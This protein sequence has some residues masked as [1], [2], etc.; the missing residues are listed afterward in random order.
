MQ[1]RAGRKG[2]KKEKKDYCKSE[3]GRLASR[4]TQQGNRRSIS[5]T[6]EKRRSQDK[7]GVVRVE[8][9]KEEKETRIAPQIEQKGRQGYILSHWFLASG[10]G[11]RKD[12]RD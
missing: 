3:L 7:R 11:K 10:K 9:P 2:G 12:L 4:C 6:P 1:E 5:I 8:I